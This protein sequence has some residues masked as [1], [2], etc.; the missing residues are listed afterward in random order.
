AVRKLGVKDPSATV[1]KFTD[2]QFADI[3]RGANVVKSRRDGT[4]TYSEVNVT[5]VEGPLKRALKLPETSTEP[6]DK[7]TVRAVLLLPVYVG[8]TRA[9]LWEKDNALRAP[10]SDE[11]RRQARGGILL[12][13]GDLEDLRLI[14]YQ[15]ALTVKPEELKPMFDR[16][17]AE[18]IIIAVLTPGASGTMDASSVLLRRLKPESTRN[19]VIE[20]PPENVEE[21]SSVRLT[22]SASAIANAITQ[23]ASSTAE[24]EQL[25]RDK[26]THIAVR[27]A[28]TIPKELAF[29]QE[30]VRSSPEVLSLDLPTIGLAQVAGTIYLKGDEAALKEALIKQGVVVTVM[31]KGWRLSVR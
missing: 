14:D 24:R 8:P 6:A 11:I 26:S 29:M 3:I 12:P 15:N 31:S 13:G 20:I 25:V 21:I 16:Y 10:L 22:K 9:Y 17:G 23:I 28:Y 18:E 5:L 27:F 4:I 1:A 30:A 2:K 7:L 19:E